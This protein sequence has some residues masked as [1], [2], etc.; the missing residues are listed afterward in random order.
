MF[1]LEFSPLW[2][3]TTV[4]SNMRYVRAVFNVHDVKGWRMM[5]DVYVGRYACR[6]GALRAA[7]G[8]LASQQ[9]GQP[10]GTLAG[11]PPAA[12]GL[13]AQIP[14]PSIVDGRETGNEAHSGSVMD[15]DKRH[16]E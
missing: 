6:R 13:H 8:A 9:V 14:E 4:Y 12:A 10:L 2:A 11:A 16:T 1:F 7:V 3:S 15:R 5:A